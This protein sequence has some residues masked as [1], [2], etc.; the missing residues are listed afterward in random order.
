VLYARVGI[1]RAVKIGETTVIHVAGGPQCDRKCH[2]R[3]GCSVRGE[4]KCDLYCVRGYGLDP[5]T[6]TCTSV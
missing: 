3:S 4:G 2:E 6:Y 5:E 1:R